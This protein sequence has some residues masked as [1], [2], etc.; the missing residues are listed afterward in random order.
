MLPDL[1]PTEPTRGH[2]RQ[3]EHPAA[4]QMEAVGR[5]VPFGLQ[6][7]LVVQAEAGNARALDDGVGEHQRESPQLSARAPTTPTP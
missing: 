1:F 2:G 5:R 3:D 4:V 7:E 6:A